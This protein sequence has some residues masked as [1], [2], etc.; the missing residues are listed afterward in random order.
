MKSPN[1]PGC[2]RILSVGSYLGGIAMRLRFVLTLLF[3]L[4]CFALMSSAANAPAEIHIPGEKI[5]PESLTSTSDG[6]VLIGSISARTIYE[7]KPGSSTAEPWIK[8]DNEPGLGILGVF[9][10]EKANRLWACFLPMPK[11]QGTPV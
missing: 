3:L 8:P 11:Y 2:I 4:V 10:D 6:R 1:R 7:V 9:A 5:Y